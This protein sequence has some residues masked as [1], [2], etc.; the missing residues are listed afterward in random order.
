MDWTAGSRA[1]LPGRG[2]VE[3]S[4]MK[5][6]VAGGTGVLGQALTARLTAGGHQAVVLTRGRSR[7]AGDEAAGRLVE[8]TPDGSAGP[9]ARELDDADAIVNLTGAGIADRR[10]TDARKDELRT[11]RLLS[12]R[13]L[14]AAIRAATPRPRTFVQN[15]GAGYYGADLSDRVLDESFPPGDDFLGDLCVAWEAEARAVSALGCRLVILRSA[16]VLTP[17]GGA[18][19]KMLP[20]FQFFVGGPIASGRQF[21]SWIHVDDWIAM[22]RWALSTP[23]VSD[24]YNAASPHPVRNREFSKALGQALHRPS[25]IPVPSFALKVMFGELAEPALILGQRVV[26]KRALAAGF[27]FQHP[28]IGE[29]LADLVK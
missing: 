15:T 21:F 9:W 4:G 26:P 13:S 10:W 24:V 1:A 11:S 14:A 29:A 3:S 22:V 5:V 25:W 28:E 18:L 2:S 7:R 27:T 17:D 23:S 12:T 20:A 6:V 19:K 8:W 16:V